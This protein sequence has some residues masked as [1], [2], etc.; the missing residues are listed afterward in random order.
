MKAK[1]DRATEH[2]AA[3]S[4]HD[5]L[6]FFS[7]QGRVYWQRIYELPLMGCT[8]SGRPIATVLRLKDAERITSMLA[9]SDFGSGTLAMATERGRIKRTKLAEFSNPRPSGLIAIKL[10]EGNHLVGVERV[11]DD[12]ELVLATA[13]GKA[14]RFSAAEVR[15]MGRASAGVAGVK[16]KTGDRVVA[17]VRAE[18]LLSLVTI[19]A[20]GFAKRTAI[21]EYRV[22]RRGGQGVTNMKISVR[23]GEVVACLAAAEEDEILVMTAGGLVVRTNVSGIREMSRSVQGVRV[24]RIDG[25]R[26]P[27]IAA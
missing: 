5:T 17:L 9:V 22:M 19:S 15:P 23:T 13:K 16:L 7:D 2:L 3:G 20:N 6:L 4:T 8:A 18:P 1:R 25:R 12:D 11:D 27:G 21:E 26:L 24:M 10:E 14:V